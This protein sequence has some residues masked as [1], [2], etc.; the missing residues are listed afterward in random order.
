MEKNAKIQ[1]IENLAK[2]IKEI[3]VNLKQLLLEEQ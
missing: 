3:L 2:L 1:I